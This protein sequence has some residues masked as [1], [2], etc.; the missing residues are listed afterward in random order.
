MSLK[1][2][3]GPYTI[4]NSKIVYKNPWITVQEDGVI[5]E[6]GQEGIFGIVKMVSGSSILPVDEN[7][8]VYL[9]K[10]FK[11]AAE[12]ETI[13]VI[14][15]GF[16]QGETALE[17]AVRELKEELGINAKEWTE[18][19]VVDPFTTVVNSP[20]YLFVAKELTLGKSNPDDGENLKILKFKFEEALSMVLSGEITHS[21]SCVLILKAARL[22]NK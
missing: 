10:E 16:D 5:R 12:R 18:L 11:Y 22:F 14:S 3:I 6:S 8:N 15:G 4:L 17:C 7:N 21:A 1:K 19:G 13:E 2:N 9:V 20:N